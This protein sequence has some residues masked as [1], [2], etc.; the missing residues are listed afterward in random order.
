MEPYK[1]ILSHTEIY[2]AIQDDRDPFRMI[3]SLKG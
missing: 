2:G 1:T 3:W